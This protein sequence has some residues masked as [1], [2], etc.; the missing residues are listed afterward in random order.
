MEED[1]GLPLRPLSKAAKTSDEIIKAFGTSV[2]FGRVQTAQFRR[3]GRQVFALWYDPFSGRSAC[4]LNA[5][6]YDYDK[7]HWVLFIDRFIDGFSDLSAEMPSMDVLIFR[8]ADG[9]VAVQASVA[10]L[11]W[12]K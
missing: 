1:T 12:K 8:G 7:S 11:P 6:Y 10:K 9:K 5:Y 3:H 2:G 4:Y